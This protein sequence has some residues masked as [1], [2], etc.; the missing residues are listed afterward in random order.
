LLGRSRGAHDRSRR[1]YCRYPC[2]PLK[3]LHWIPFGY[4]N[5]V[6]WETARGTAKAA[7]FAGGEHDNL[8]QI[9]LA[10]KALAV[11]DRASCRSDKQRK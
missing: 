5:H 10:G 3:Q 6:I 9:K 11:V 8:I 2:D 7:I 4:I 1:K